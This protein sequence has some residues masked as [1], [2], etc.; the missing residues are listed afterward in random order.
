MAEAH[1]RFLRRNLG[2]VVA[3]ML[4]IARAEQLESGTR[5]LAAE[6]LV[7]LCEAREKVCTRHAGERAGG[8]AG[9]LLTLCVSGGGIWGKSM[10]ASGRGP[11]A[12]GCCWWVVRDALN[13]VR[14]LA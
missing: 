13:V 11:D 8:V 7:T 2:D 1:P 3:A 5:S 12:E 6:F 9:A 4:S 14:R 10:R